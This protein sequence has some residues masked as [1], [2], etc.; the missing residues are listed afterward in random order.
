MTVIYN[1]TSEA[2]S[3]V[4]FAKREIGGAISGRLW[5]PVQ[6]EENMPQELARPA[7]AGGTSR[8]GQTRAAP[9]IHGDRWGR[10]PAAT[11]HNQPGSIAHDPVSARAPPAGP[12]RAPQCGTAEEGWDNEGGAGAAPDAHTDAPPVR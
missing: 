6:M 3:V 9:A 8:P 12:P 5:P 11:E 1:S 2:D 7:T 10:G 4:Q